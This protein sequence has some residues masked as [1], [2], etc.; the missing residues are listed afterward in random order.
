M[1]KRFGIVGMGL[2]GM[3]YM[4]GLFE[5]EPDAAAP[6]AAAEPAAPASVQLA[7]E[8]VQAPE[9]AP[10]PD[11]KPG[12]AEVLDKAG[13]APVE[14]DPG[15]TY[16][17][18]FLA[19]NG[20]T[21]DNPAVAAAFTGDFSLLKAELSAKGVQGWEQ[22]L[23]L[24]EQS[25]QRAVEGKQATEAEVGTIVTDIAEQS[26]VDWEAAVAHVSG[27]AG[28]EEKSALNTLLADPK[29]A[30]IAAA[31]I[32]NAYINGGDTEIEPAAR[33]TLDGAR[34]VN[35]GAGGPLSRREYTAEMGKLRQSL[36][37]DYMH[38]PQAQALFRRLQ[39]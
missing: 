14:G 12:D 6:V 26:G 24:A 5:G 19:G 37:D 20:F 21:A 15:L 11:A 9:P 27:S 29:T 38:S 39:R 23:G 35:A 30:H 18:K 2:F 3:A 10:A 32:T 22:A 34:P 25:Y 36:G 1:N 33:A 7:V 17:L 8:P 16:A 28:Q 31:Y 4:A 13:F